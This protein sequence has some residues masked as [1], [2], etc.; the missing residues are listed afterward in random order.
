MRTCRTCGN[1]ERNIHYR[2]TN[3]GRDYAADPPRFSRRAKGMTAIVAGVLVLVALAVAIPLLISSKDRT[4]SEQAAADRAAA[5]RYAAQLRAEERPVAGRLT[6]VADRAGAPAAQRLRA[7]RAQ[8]VAFQTAIT[9]DARGR[10]ADGRLKGVDPGDA[11]QQHPA[12]RRARRRDDAGHPHR[13]LRLR[14]L[15]A[16]RGQ[17]GQGRRPPRLRLLRLARLRH[18]GLRDLP[19]HPQPVRGRTRPGRG[20]APARVPERARPAPEGRVHLD[21]RDTSQPLPMLAAAG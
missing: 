7:R 3:C 4:K 15:A 14:R 19:G 17:A 2:C 6:V 5:R 21:P 20:A 12:R 13:P 18:R 10:V 8:V 9:R 1:V 11:V 16:G